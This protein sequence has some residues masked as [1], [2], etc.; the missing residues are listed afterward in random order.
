MH[1]KIVCFL[2][3][4]SLANLLFANYT[5]YT[6][7][8]PSE[9]PSY[10]FFQGNV[11]PLHFYNVL[12]PITGV[13]NRPLKFE[14]GAKVSKGQPLMSIQPN[15]QQDAYRSA[16]LSYLRAK[17]SYN[18]AMEK[19]AGQ[20]LLY[21]NKILARNDYEQFKNNLADQKLSLQESLYNLKSIIAKISDNSPAQQKLI[22]SLSNLSLNDSQVY[23]ALNHS[24]DQVNII[25][26]SSGIALAPTKSSDSDS[27]ST[28][29]LQQ[30]TSVKLN[31]VLMSIGDFS[32]IKVD[33]EVNEVSINQLRKGQLAEVSGAAF[34][35]ITLKGKVIAIDYQAKSGGFSTGLPQFPVTVAVEHLTLQQQS[36]IHYGMSAQ[37]KID[38]Q[39]PKQ[40]MIPINAVQTENDKDYVKKIINGK[41]VKTAITTGTTTQ[42]SVS[43]I[44]GLKPGDKI[45]ITH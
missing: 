14:F 31:Q 32:G 30:G 21:K 36:L 29:Q 25:A 42:N 12:S 11:S 41:L 19:F 24:F 3:S 17:T 9:V 44:S 23:S 10:L 15:D 45:A 5:S 7:K 2:L 33:I 43:V 1:Q 20:E 40:I 35:G 22:N 26:P 39:S 16:L 27:S 38:L 8:V 37:V 34:P 28:S 6:V 4:I 18:E 13:V